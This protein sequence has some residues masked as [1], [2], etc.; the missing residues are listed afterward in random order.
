MT[1]RSTKARHDSPDADAFP[2]DN[3]IGRFRPRTVLLVDDDTEVLSL[4]AETMSGFGHRVIQAKDGPEALKCL[5]KY[6]SIDC[7]FSDVVMPNGMTGVQLMAAAR[8]VRPGLPALLAS[9]YPKDYV[10]SL[11]DIPENVSFIA[12]PYL[13]TDLFALLDRQA[14]L[15]QHRPGRMAAQ[16]APAGTGLPV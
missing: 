3:A 7:I 15:A 13:L 14:D 2:E 5:L 12:K 1:H 16:A 10:S 4:L 6:R 11:G 8:A 9:S